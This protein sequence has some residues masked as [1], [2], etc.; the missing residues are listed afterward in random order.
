MPQ[1]TGT[2]RAEGATDDAAAAA[3]AGIGEDDL[4]AIR[5]RVLNV[6][7]H[8]LRTPVTTLRG[9]ADALS[10][11]DPA[12]AAEHVVPAIQRNA[13]RLERLVDDLLI[14]NGI[15]TALPV[16]RPEAVD[17]AALVRSTWDAIGGA[18]R[19]LAVVAEP[20]VAPLRALVQPAA[21]GGALERVLENARLL[22]DEPPTVRI[23]RTGGAVVIEVDSPGP[24]L[25]EEEVRHAAELL[26]RGHAAVMRTPG[27]GL[28]LPVARALVEHADG[29]LAV[30]GR[31]GGGLVTT[32]SVPAVEEEP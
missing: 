18:A 14:A 27:L 24:P 25:D 5:T 16:G 12:T 29:A 32:L 15:A 7:G 10:R 9:L 31:P 20:S 8:E 2:P 4:R 23:T 30:A 28:G 13:E 22:G 17:V 3:A 26:F 21:L 19:A 6:V 11:V 1:V